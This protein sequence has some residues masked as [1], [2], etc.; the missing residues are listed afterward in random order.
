MDEATLKNLRK[1]QLLQLDI[2]KA[3]KELC[4]ANDIPFFLIGGTLLGAVRHKGFIPWDDDLDIGM[5]R[6]DY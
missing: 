4:L 5:Q 6:A 1:I 2:A 3:V